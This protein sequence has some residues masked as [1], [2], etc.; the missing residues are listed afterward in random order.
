M[1]R[2]GSSIDSGRIAEARAAKAIKLLA[3]MIDR[4]VANLISRMLEDDYWKVE[5]VEIPIAGGGG[6]ARVV[7]YASTHR[8]FLIGDG[9]YILES[10]QKSKR[11]P[12]YSFVIR[13]VWNE[14]V[15]YHSSTAEGKRFELHRP[16]NVVCQVHT[17]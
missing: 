16:R 9:K 8:E 4:I 7:L 10:I 3:H 6:A 2:P 13:P 1:P 12:E 17:Y 15:F 14:A 11:R 5:R